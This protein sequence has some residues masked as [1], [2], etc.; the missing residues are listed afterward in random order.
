MVVGPAPFQAI[1]LAP[2]VAVKNLALLVALMV[3]G[4]DRCRPYDLQEYNHQHWM[5]IDPACFCPL[6]H[7]PLLLLLQG[8]RYR[9]L[10]HFGASSGKTPLLG[11]VL[12]HLSL[13]PALGNEHLNHFVPVLVLTVAGRAVGYAECSHL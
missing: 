7:G 8:F 5:A 13:D 12:R 9:F 3:G 11:P 2:T 1:R 10:F 6:P 4:H